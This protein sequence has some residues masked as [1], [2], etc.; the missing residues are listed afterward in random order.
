MVIF[1]TKWRA[2]EQ[3]GEG[4]ATNQPNNNQTTNRTKPNK[5]KFQGSKTISS[6]Q[7]LLNPLVLQLWRL[8]RTTMMPGAD[9]KFSILGTWSLASFRKIYKELTENYWFH[10][11]KSV[12][13]WYY[14]WFRNPVNSPVEGQVVNIPLF[15]RFYIYIY[16]PSGCLG[17]LNHQQYE[18]NIGGAG[19]IVYTQIWMHGLGRP[20]LLHSKRLGT[21][22]ARFRMETLWETSV[23]FSDQ[24]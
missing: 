7:G 14:W 4:W 23:L 11:C 21:L 17:F 20:T 9:L 12:V 18:S 5:T 3:Q 16:I 13:V 6:R 24:C 1:P 2:N 10:V 19:W 22:V 8:K 15:T